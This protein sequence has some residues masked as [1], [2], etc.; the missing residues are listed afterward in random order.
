YRLTNCRPDHRQTRIE[1]ADGDRNGFTSHWYRA[2]VNV[3]RDVTFTLVACDYGGA[4]YEQWLQ[5]YL[6]SNGALRT[7][8]SG[9]YRLGFRLVSNESLSRVDFIGKLIRADVQSSSRHSTFT[10]GCDH[11]L[12]F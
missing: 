6:L 5:Q 4:R 11:L 12:Y 1:T 8:R 2:F 3:S 10:H 7:R 9:R